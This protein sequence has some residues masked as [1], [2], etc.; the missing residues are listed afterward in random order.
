MNLY[1]AFQ[2]FLSCTASKNSRVST[3]RLESIAKS[4]RL[5]KFLQIENTQPDLIEY[6]TAHGSRTLS[7]KR[8]ELNLF[9]VLCK[10]DGFTRAV[11]MPY[12]RTYNSQGIPQLVVEYSEPEMPATI[13]G[14]ARAVPLSEP[15]V[16]GGI[17]IE[18]LGMLDTDYAAMLVCDS[19]AR[20]R[21]IGG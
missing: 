11:P 1:L 7:I 9:L 6:F 21:E 18:D 4:E 5:D 14:Y 20:N 17:Y 12:N 16:R 8:P 19:F 10:G 2:T 15:Y 13:A 3:Y